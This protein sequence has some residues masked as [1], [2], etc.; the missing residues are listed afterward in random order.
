MPYLFALGLWFGATSFAKHISSEHGAIEFVDDV[1]IV[2]ASV[3]LIGL[4][5]VVT[6]I[7]E[8]ARSIYYVYVSEYHDMRSLFSQKIAALVCYLAFGAFFMAKPRLMTRI[9]QRNSS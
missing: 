9:Y 3:F 5:L 4:Y 6:S 1:R 8:L 2:T 7:P